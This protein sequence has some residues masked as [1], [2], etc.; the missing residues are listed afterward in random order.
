MAAGSRM[1]SLSRARVKCHTGQSRRLAIGGL[2]GGCR[3]EVTASQQNEYI[4]ERR[5][6]CGQVSQCPARC[7][8]MAKQGRQGDMR[9]L[10]GQTV[11]IGAHAGGADRGQTSQLRLFERL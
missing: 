2:L 6:P 1:K 5:V 4:L 11:S 3:I 9:V 10:D 8:Q 7:L